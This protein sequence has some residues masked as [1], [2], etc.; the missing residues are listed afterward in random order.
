MRA[1]LAAMTPDVVYVCREGQNEELRFSLRSLVN[2]P[3]GDVWIFGGHPAWVQGLRSVRVPQNA[4]KQQNVISNVIAACLNSRVSDP[5]IL[6]NDDFYVMRPIESVPVMHR[7]TIA[8]V[9]DDYRD[10]HPSSR[11]TSRI[12]RTRKHLIN[13]GYPAP[14]SYE[15]HAPMVFHKKPLLELLM[16]FTP[17]EYQWRTL[18]G[19]TQAIGGDH[20]DDVKVWRSGQTVAEGPFLSSS[21]GAFAVVRPL[22]DQQ[23]P[24]PSPYEEPAAAPLTKQ[25]D[26]MYVSPAR[27][28][29]KGVLIAYAGEVMTE[30]EARRRGLEVEQP[31]PEAVPEPDYDAMNVRQ[32]R[33][34]AESRGL[35]TPKR[36]KRA[37]LLAL[38]R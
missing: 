28:T 14:L 9:L 20:V 11:Y 29:R 32:L 27:I 10:R 19:N 37:D 5:F 31:E 18:Y 30:R 38:L 13:L 33:E 7:G 2:L 21:D 22:L 6:M 8:S 4:D 26:G 1:T 23:F 36:A 24:D 35:D 16:T 17:G 12:E 34:L 3:H 25:E 15:L